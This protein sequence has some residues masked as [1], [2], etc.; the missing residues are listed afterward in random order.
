MYHRSFFTDA[1]HA[2]AIGRVRPDLRTQGVR[3]WEAI[4]VEPGYVWRSAGPAGIHD[5]GAEIDAGLVSGIAVGSDPR[6][7]IIG[8]RNAGVWASTDEGATWTQ[9]AD[10][11]ASLQ[12]MVVG[13]F[14]GGPAPL[15]LA[16]SGDVNEAGGRDPGLVGVFR[17]IDGGK[18]WSVLDAGLFGTHFRSHDVNVVIPLDRDRV[19]V[20][21]R[22]GLYFSKDGGRNFGD[23]ADHSNGRPMLSGHVTDVV[24]DG[25]KLA[26]AVAGDPPV[27]EDP[28]PT[29]VIAQR[30]TPTVDPGLY[31]SDLTAG[32]LAAFGAPARLT[33]TG[34]SDTP[35]YTVLGHSGRFWM[36]SASK[37]NA[38]RQSFGVAPPSSLHS[39]HLTRRDPVTP[40][41]WGTL[42]A[43][44]LD[45]LNPF[46]TSYS[47]AVAIEPSGSASQFDGWFGSVS[48]N[49]T[50]ADVSS[51][52]WAMTSGIRGLDGVHA[53]IHAIRV[54]DLP[55]PTRRILVGSDGGLAIS[56][57]A[58]STWDQ[59]NAHASCLVW[60]IAFARVSATQARL[61]CGIQDNG[62]VLG[63]G[64]FDPS[65]PSDW[66][67][68]RAGGGDGGACAFIPRD[69][70]HVASDDPT[71]AF[72]TLNGVLQHATPV[73]AGVWV[74]DDDPQGQTDPV[75][76]IYTETVAVGRSASGEWDRVFFGN[77]HD[78]N[79][80]GILRRRDGA[81]SS[82]FTTVH[83]AAPYPVGAHG[84]FRA[85]ITATAIA[86][87]DPATERTTPGA[88]DQLW[89]GLAN[90]E[91]WFSSDAGDT[92]T[93]I[94]VGPGVF[95]VSSIAID[96][97][98]SRRVA[99]AFAGFVE[100]PIAGPS[101]HVWLTENRGASWRDIGGKRGANGWVPDLPV[102][103]AAFTRTDPPA[104]LIATDIGVV[105]TRGPHLGERWT[106][107]G[108]NLPRVPCSQIIALNDVAAATPPSLD[109]GL[110]PVA[111]ATFGRSAF[112]LVRPSG[113][114]AVI[115][116]DGGFGAMRVGETR[117]RTL[118]V[119]NVGNAALALGAPSLA[120]P[121]SLTGLPSGSVD[122]RHQVSFTVECHPTAAG[123]QVAELTV[124][125][126]T[127]AV[128]AEAYAD[129]PPRLAMFP[130]RINFGDVADGTTV[131]EAI[132]LQNLGQ[133]ELRITAVTA[134]GAA[135]SAFSFAPAMPPDLVLA[136]GEER[137]L[138]VRFTASSVGS[139]HAGTWT[140]ACND[141]IV[142]ASHFQ[143]TTRG[144]VTA[145]SHHGIPHWIYWAGGGVVVALIVIGVI[146]HEKHKDKPGS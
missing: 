125:G 21:T 127:V 91:V 143:I 42:S 63:E 36:M 74:A 86:P 11:L 84:E 93:Q 61:L 145:A 108:A 141:P 31:L 59:L 123:P 22:V 64:P 18:T 114:E 3:D 126:Q 8:T 116:F 1:Y 107:L 29:E 67:W 97:S 65:R 121:F 130:R 101:G 133:S 105:M 131:E 112:L 23:D 111:V 70:G 44:E 99:I 69:R 13:R 81:T 83:P 135:S 15:L 26:A 48:L 138:T 117:R 103:S 139:E 95:P 40:G 10:R 53:D 109:A 124:A 39:I 82:P 88:W 33:S 16:G 98:D 27:T 58:G 54:D 94:A 78:R 132:H 76:F 41:G 118:T 17:S 50:H 73:S 6:Q 102:L 80:P 19:I 79:G 7:L 134:V 14:D 146:C 52:S 35:S 55:G 20:A 57:N 129:G 45:S 122:P 137:T 72:T 115:E 60:S 100:G 68:N 38:L 34:G 66:T 96:P 43:A 85:M 110:P 2:P 46:Q 30:S 104:L 56:R 113:G 89:I 128:S 24:I 140:L 92:L 77:A 62:T 28:P 90:G 47:H 120:A 119:H 25:T 51:G 75:G 71:S 4:A 12:T 87:A 9:L 142:D 5:T 144:R 106:R 37:L 136:P 49:R 32:G